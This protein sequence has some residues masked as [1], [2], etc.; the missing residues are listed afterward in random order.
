MKYDKEITRAARQGRLLLLYGLWWKL[1]PAKTYRRN[2]K[3]RRIFECH[4]ASASRP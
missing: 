3:T 4:P 2:P 1:D